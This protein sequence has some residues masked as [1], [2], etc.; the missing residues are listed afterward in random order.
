M[1]VHIS[2]NDN[3]CQR[4]ID[5]IDKP[6]MARRSQTLV[7]LSHRYS[8]YEGRTENEIGDAAPDIISSSSMPGESK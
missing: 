1:E 8:I 6:S 3:E 4:R 2:T 5:V 7:A